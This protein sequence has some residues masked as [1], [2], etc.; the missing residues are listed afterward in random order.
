[1]YQIHSQR[2]E[3]E[4]S[5]KYRMTFVWYFLMEFAGQ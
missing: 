1:M 2:A 4:E 5:L 3:V